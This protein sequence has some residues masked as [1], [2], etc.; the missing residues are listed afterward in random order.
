MTYQDEI[1]NQL[2]AKYESAVINHKETPSIPTAQHLSLAR[3]NLIVFI[4]EA[5]I[6]A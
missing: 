5:K 1:I 3:H 2:M 6:N 4:K